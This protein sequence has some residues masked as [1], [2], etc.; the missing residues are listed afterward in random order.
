M[1]APKTAIAV[2][3]KAKLNLPANLAEDMANEIAQFKGRL[4]APSGRRIKTDEKMFTLPNDDTS[5]TLNVIIVDFV[6]RNEYYESAWNPNA[7]VPPNCFAIGTE[8]ASMIPSD[9][10][11]EKQHENC[12]SCWANQFDS[13]VGKGKACSNT[14]LLAVIAPDADSDTP[15]L[16][17]KVTSTALK[18]FDSYVASVIQTMQRPPRGVITQ[19][20]FDQTV[21]HSSLRFSNPQACTQEQ[22]ALAYSRREEAMQL[23]LQEPDVSKFVATAKAKPK[24]KPLRKAA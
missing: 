9:N 4:S 8:I 21:K 22:M 14:R 17:L 13:G 5:D 12:A 23:L 3:K 16:L 1:A 20:T 2:P 10:S 18:N 15:L 7:I 6:A 24:G 11:P 19:I